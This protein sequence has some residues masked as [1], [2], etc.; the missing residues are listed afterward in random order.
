MASSDSRRRAWRVVVLFGLV[1]LFAD[2][3]YEG[4]RSIIG[5][6]LG[7]LGASAVVVAAL[8]G[9]G[10]WL[11]H[12]LRLLSGYWSDRTRA[13]WAFTLLGYGLNLLAVPLL[14]LTRT[15]PAAAVLVL[16]ERMGKALRAPARDAL[17]SRATKE[18][19]HGRGFGLHEALDQVG[20]M[21][22]PLLVAGVLWARGEMRLA[23]AALALPAG[24]AL[25]LLLLARWTYPE[26]PKRAYPSR[27]ELPGGTAL[28]GAFWRYLG[29][30]ALLA[31]GFVDF[32]LMAYAFTQPGKMAVLS[33]PLLYMLAMGVDAVAALI[34]G[35][36]YDRHGLRVMAGAIALALP[37]PALVLLTARPVWA[38]LGAALWGV[39]MGAQESVMR[40]GV[41]AL[42]P[43]DRRATAYGLFNTGYGLA[44]FLGSAVVGGLLDWHPGAAV[45]VA[46][47]LQTL[48][49]AA[50][51]RWRDG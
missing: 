42:T 23:F 19:G 40:A 44:W 15:W 43:E 8:A 45:L 46:T 18:V 27:D 24:V 33:A 31:A 48:A 6:Y 37:A 22:G 16:V 21:L 34:F 28:P 50:F 39:G 2:M 1:S 20:A 17:L 36:L 12:G 49:L 10:E 38:I 30:S 4:A 5:P 13:Y 3:T 29:A 14:A 47:A 35:R 7:V 51:A 11:S 32:P 26:T 9:L 25:T 41:A